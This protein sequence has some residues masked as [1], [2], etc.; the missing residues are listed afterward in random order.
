MPVRFFVERTF[1]LRGRPVF[2]ACGHMVDGVVAPGQRVRAPAGLDVPVASVEGVH[3]GGGA[4]CLGL[5][6]RYADEAQLAR[7]QA[8][9]LAGATLELAGGEAAQ[10]P[11]RP[12]DAVVYTPTQRGRDLLATTGYAALRPGQACRVAAVVRGAYVVPE[13][14]EA[15]PGGGVYF[16]E[17]SAPAG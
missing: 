14:F 9:G 2:V 12:G 17:F 4:G 11:F 3:L 13:G 7:W 15:E 1:G 5:V 6:F 10:C 16:T 8:L